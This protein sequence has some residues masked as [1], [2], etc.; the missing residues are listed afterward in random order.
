[1]TRGQLLT[2]SGYWFA[3]NFLWGSILMTALA[4][5]SDGEV[6]WGQIGIDDVVSRLEGTYAEFMAEI[7]DTGHPV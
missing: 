4:D 7:S 6:D 3:N 1:M 2:I 5:L